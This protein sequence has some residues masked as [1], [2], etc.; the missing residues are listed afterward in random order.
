MC[1]LLKR[2]KSPPFCVNFPTPSIVF[3]MRVCAALALQQPLYFFFDPFG[4]PRLR[5]S[6]ELAATW[7]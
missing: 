1:P 4:R 3:Q 6:V 7:I 2:S 5:F